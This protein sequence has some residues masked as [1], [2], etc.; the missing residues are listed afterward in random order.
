MLIYIT[1]LIAYLFKV[2]IT[3]IACFN[4]EIEQ[5]NIVNIF[6]NIKKDLCSVLVAY[7]LLNKFK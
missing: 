7:K 6:V 4:L 3:I 5:F 1:T 2:I